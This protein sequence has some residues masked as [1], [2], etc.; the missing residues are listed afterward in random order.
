MGVKSINGC[1][2]VAWP[3]MSREATSPNTW[4]WGG[5]GQEW[6]W[7][8]SL[9]PC[10]VVSQE[11]MA[12]HCENSVLDS[13]KPWSYPAGLFLHPKK[14]EKNAVSGGGNLYF[15]CCSPTPKTRK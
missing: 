8:A 3:F 7:V 13:M 2:G 4:G 10:C 11:H 12:D 9:N 1:D 14:G 15:C 6:Q 5:G